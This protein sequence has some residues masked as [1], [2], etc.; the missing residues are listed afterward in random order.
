[1]NE[2]ELKVM[3][4][5]S[6]LAG[7]IEAKK[8]DIDKEVEDLNRQTSGLI[9]SANLQTSDVIKSA[10]SE[11]TRTRWFSLFVAIL[12]FFIGIA[13]YLIVGSFLA[14][15][16]VSLFIVPT[17][18][19][20]LSIYFLGSESDIFS[21][22][23]TRVTYVPFGSSIKNHVTEFFK[24]AARCTPILE[25]AIHELQLKNKYRL[26]IKKTKAAL[27]FYVVGVPSDFYELLEGK[28]PQLGQTDEQMVEHCCS[29]IAKY[30]SNRETEISSKTLKLLYLEHHGESTQSLWRKEK[31]VIAGELANI[32]FESGRLP[33]KE[34][35]GSIKYTVEDVRYILYQLDEFS[36]NRTN[37]LLLEYSRYLDYSQAFLLFL[38]NNDIKSTCDVSIIKI[39]DVLRS[40]ESSNFDEA[41][42]KLLKILSEESI[43]SAYSD[44]SK[45]KTPSFA[46]VSL[47]IFLENP[48][49]REIACR[50]AAKDEHVPEIAFAYNEFN[51]KL[52]IEG[53]I[54]GKRFVSVDY[55]VKHSDEKIKEKKEEL[56]GF[57]NETREIKTLLENG[58]WVTSQ[59]YVI[60]K[61]MSKISRSTDRIVIKDRLKSIF[62]NLSIST[63]KRFL[64]TK[65]VNA[66]LITFN[67]STGPLAD[68]I[69][70]F[71]DCEEGKLKQ[72]GINLKFGEKQSYNFVQYTDSARVGV[73]PRGLSFEEFKKLWQKNFAIIEKKRRELIQ[74]YDWKKGDLTGVEVV[75]HRFDPSEYNYYAYQS[76]LA[77]T[78]AVSKI[79]ELLKEELKPEELA[80]LILYEGKTNLLREILE[81][82]IANL[83]NDKIR[84]SSVQEELLGKDEL[85]KAV[86]KEIGFDSIHN[87][88]LYLLKS[89]ET[90]K[91]KSYSK[92]ADIIFKFAK[93]NDELIPEKMCSTI[94]KVY[95]EALEVVAD[96]AP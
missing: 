69:D 50:L 56:K 26:I 31:D 30:L 71:V 77:V 12:W 37:A 34:G 66:Y 57:E 72:Y 41:M 82:P 93:A 29:E 76:P 59:W 67:C 8:E 35:K 68:L 61:A 62:G 53:E 54:D 22:F 73:I 39:S 91:N 7:Q 84:L 18:T 43:A 88:S 63:I 1:M 49:M 83:V 75:I 81:Y 28:T 45:E 48:S 40:I 79:Q 52:G 24:R 51:K 27:D 14:T 25:A 32:L 17:V 90:E 46:L 11:I 85:K 9:E 47:P 10:K 6:E 19:Y 33:P 15:L 16:I 64:E 92:I 2:T 60:Q 38:R 78:E 13:T 42:V 86:L 4:E 96:I 95:S 80:S 36:L 70:C 87:L 21:K 74:D 94:A 55:L 23:D 20:L 3:K 65:T 44:L 89:D 5:I 58:Q